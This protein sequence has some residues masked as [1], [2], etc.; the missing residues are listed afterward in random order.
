MLFCDNLGG[1]VRDEFVSKLQQH[2]VFCHFLPSGCTDLLQLV[3]AGIGSAVKTLM[4]RYYEEWLIEKVDGVSN[5]DRIARKKEEGNH[6][7]M[8]EQR[9]L[10][11]HLLARAWTKLCD[12][13]DFYHVASKVG[14]NL[15]ADGSRDNLIK[16]EGLDTYSFK[17]DDAR[18]GVNKACPNPTVKEAAKAK[19]YAA[20]NAWTLLGDEQD[21]EDEISEGDGE[22]D[23]EVVGH[24]EREREEQ[25]A[26]EAGRKGRDE[27]E[28][29]GGEVLDPEL[30]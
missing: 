1:Q 21:S 6:V 17:A 20:R 15:A 9:V 19:A 11:T 2:G 28:G 24:E 30:S 25:R 27:E 26:R 3:D 14:N 10:Y 23:G 12:T 7:S 4:N 16:I 29:G 5:I 22:S 8:R 13:V 18:W